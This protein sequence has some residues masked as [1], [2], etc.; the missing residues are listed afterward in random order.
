MRDKAYH[1]ANDAEEEEEDREAEAAA[2]AM[3]WGLLCKE[4][5]GGRG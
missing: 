1:A 4:Q 5:G 3:A 2:L